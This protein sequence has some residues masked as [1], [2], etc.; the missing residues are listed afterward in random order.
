MCLW[1][2]V[3]VIVA[4]RVLFKR[5]I[6]PHLLEVDYIKDLLFSQQCI[7]EMKLTAN[8]SYRVLLLS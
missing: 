8:G 3:S 1:K 7:C 4:R 5:N 6:A 2:E